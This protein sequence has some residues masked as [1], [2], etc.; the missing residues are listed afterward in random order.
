[1]E[2]ENDR[3]ER[4]HCG[5]WN[6]AAYSVLVFRE[7]RASSHVA[8]LAGFLLV[9]LAGSAAAA[10]EN[11][12]APPAV[13]LTNAAQVRNLTVAEAARALQTRLRGVVVDESF[14][15]ERAL[16]LADQTAGIYLLAATNLFS[17][18]RREDLLEVEGVTDPGEFAPILLVKAARKV[19]TAPM[20][21]ARKATYQQLM[22]GAL[23]AQLVD[24][25]GVVR[26]CNRTAPDSDSWQMVV[27]TDGGSVPV[28]FLASQD[29]HL[30]EDAEV[31]FLAICFYQFSHKRQVLT[32]VLQVPAGMLVRVER[33][34]P[35]DSYSAPLRSADSLLR[36]TPETAYGHRVHL[37]GVVTHSQPGELVWVRD[38]TS[39]LR[40]R[41]RQAEHLQPGDRI[42]VLGFLVYGSYTLM[43]EDAI[44]RSMG[45]TNPP[46]PVTL[47][48]TSDAFDH[49]EDLVAIEAR[50]VETQPV[51]DGL[52]VFL[53]K[54]GTFF[55]A[56]L[57][58]PANPRQYPD[59]QPGS[60]VC[61]TGIC[62]A[63]PEEM[64]PT[65]GV[66]RPQS[67]QILLRS[68]ADLTIVKPPPWWTLKHI[69]VL[70]GIVAGGSFLVTAAVMW[71]A[72]RRLRE[73][74][75]RRAMAE[76]EFAAILAE[77]NRVAREIHDTLAQGL[78]ATSL[79]LRLARKQTNG[80][81]ESLSH[82]LETAQQLV[83]DSLEEA[84]NSIWN[85][86]SHVLE[87]GDLASALRGIL[88]QM[89][90]GTETETEFEVNGRT[91]RLA[92][93]IE[94]NLLRIGQEAITNATKHAKAKRIK[95]ELDFGEKQFRLTVS[96]DGQGFDTTR[97]ASA[98]DG[99]G[100]VGM[101]E[102]AAH[103][104]GKLNVRSA[105]GQGARINLTVP[106]S[107]E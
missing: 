9:A 90:D 56:V 66:W 59:W 52:A 21:L 92:P 22:T 6:P 20:P 2:T 19:G 41:T 80:A 35:A 89:A 36:F 87:N 97:P 82:H 45:A 53:E 62:S 15:P 95:V 51:L 25:A 74:A 77:R 27:A 46:A 4:K 17:S 94:N 13:V 50:L 57:R 73:Q 54:S 43:L 44:F 101:Q 60:K 23:D 93:V 42:D 8:G 106:L 75:Q 10:P 26:Q 48:N 65:M 18:F 39:G 31:R 55:R 107:G 79:Q 102:R 100:L 28:R 34:A 85:M 29:P 70:L 58:L 76:A 1:M 47:T 88:K 99:F 103:L 86:R 69:I 30:Q 68:P 98:K 12:P 104:K 63:V 49:E 3:C 105:P 61:L 7:M 11:S 96:D 40:I 14:P 84:R 16:I 33:S 24:I 38:G 67:F 71:L 5:G 83:S 91:R 78:V 64:S 32:P 81:A 72:R 37:R